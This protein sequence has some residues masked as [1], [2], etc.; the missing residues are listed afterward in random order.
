MRTNLL[1]ILLLALLGNACTDDMLDNNGAIE[2]KSRSVIDDFSTT[3][4]N[5][6][7]D[8]EHQNLIRLSTGKSIPTPWAPGST[9]TSNEEFANDI[10]KENGWTMLFHT[11]KALDMYENIYY[12]F[13]YNKLT[14]FLKVFY[15][16]AIGGSNPNGAMW[17]FH[18][19]NGTGN[20]F[21]NLNN[22]VALPDDASNKASEVCISNGLKSP[23]D[24]FQAGWNGF[25]LEVPYT[26]NYKDLLFALSTHNMAVT[27]YTF[28]GTS[29]TKIE[30]T[31]V[32]TVGKESG[33]FKAISNLGSLGAKEL[34][35]K[36]KK[37]VDDKLE[38]DTTG[39]IKAKFGTKIIKAL[40]KLSKGDIKSALSEG[41]KF[42]FGSSTATETQQVHL[43]AN[44]T[45]NLS[46]TS[47]SPSTGMPFAMGNINLYN[48]LNNTK[49]INFDAN[50]NSLVLPR[51]STF[52][53]TGDEQYLGVWTLRTT[54]IVY[55]TRYSHVTDNI[56]QMGCIQNGT[57]AG[58]YQV[59]SQIGGVEI[60]PNLT[61]YITQY[62]V[63]S[64][65]VY[66]T[67]LDGESKYDSY[68]LLNT[69]LIYSDKSL[70]L[71]ESPLG[72]IFYNS[73]L[74]RGSRVPVGYDYYYDWGTQAPENILMI[75]TVDITYNYLGKIHKITSSRTYK[76]KCIVDISKDQQV[77]QSGSQRNAYV[78]NTGKYP[79]EDR[80]VESLKIDGENN[81]TME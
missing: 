33:L 48:V 60:N 40:S 34:I 2:P 28:S 42:I 38:K 9:I 46:G 68:S 64:E 44:G 37:K 15:Y 52:A 10:K 31:I 79:L 20:S 58:P 73:P 3:N 57:L 67:Q 5:L 6:I 16:N 14:G 1:L 18:I 74:V 69:D 24:G 53:S 45:I 4:P 81:Q 63:S 29:E 77:L 50:Y 22:Y 55:V 35:N 49:S 78:V 26:S 30:G 61:P 71:K 27:S 25:E 39:V 62:N 65:L 21:F 23:V 80:S 51:Q 7:D 13:L 59:S 72:K 70:E 41:L 12:I 54:P 76:T 11:F 36:M 47:L 17:Y 8:W 19:M 75:I 66:A 32:K 43:T 56:V